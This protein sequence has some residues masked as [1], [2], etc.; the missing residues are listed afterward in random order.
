MFTQNCL[1]ILPTDVQTDRRTDG[2]DVTLEAT[3]SKYFDGGLINAK[4][5]KK[6]PS[7]D[8][9]L[10]TAAQATISNW[11]ILGRCFLDVLSAF[12]YPKEH[13][14]QENTLIMLLAWLIHV[15]HG[16]KPYA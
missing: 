14:L 6:L 16:L 2:H 15:F 4:I 8:R 5:L 7:Y 11:H 9:R 1:Q 10:G 13:I 12:R 3:P